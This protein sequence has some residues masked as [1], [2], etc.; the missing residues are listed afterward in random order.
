[1]PGNQPARGRMKQKPPPIT[2][3][4]LQQAVQAFR[5]RGGMIKVLP[6]QKD[7]LQNAVGQRW[8]NSAMRRD[9]H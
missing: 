6:R 4:T 8:C 1:M 9:S 7:I 5:E 3:E 2:A